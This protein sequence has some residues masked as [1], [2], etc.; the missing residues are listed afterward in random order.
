MSNKIGRFEIISRLAQSSFSTV[1]KALDPENG[2]TLALK[3]VPLSSV[4]D[5]QSLVKNVFEEADRSKPLNSHNIAALFGVGDED[6]KLIAGS[7]YVQGNSIATNLSRKEGFS[8]WDMQ[9][10][11]RQVCQALDH[12]QVHKV[13]H[14]SLEPAKIMVQWDGTVK[15]LGFGISSMN[16]MAAAPTGIPEVLYYLSPE[17]LRGEVC[18]HRSAL[19]SL[20]AILYEMATEQKAFSGQ[21]PERVRAAILEGVPAY[22]HRVKPNVSQGLSALIM[23][24]ISKSPKDRYQSGQE[25]MRDLEQ[26]NASPA[27]TTVVPPAPRKPQAAAAAA[28]FAGKPPAAAA[29]RGLAGKPQAAAAAPRVTGKPLPAAA[30]GITG[31]ASIPRPPVPP[32]PAPKVSASTAPARPSVPPAPKIAVDPLMAE[33][34]G[35]KASAPARRSFSE[36]EELPP[37]KD[38]FVSPSPAEKP[39][40]EQAESA[41]VLPP[42]AF[43][44]SAPEKPALQVREAAQ[45]AVAEIRKTPPKLFMYAVSVAGLVIAVIVAAMIIHN[46]MADH[47]NGSAPAAQAQPAQA[48]PAPAPSSTPPSTPAPPAAPPAAAQAQPAPAQPAPAPVAQQPEATAQAEPAV[49]VTEPRSSRKHRTRTPAAPKL[50]Q[51]AVASTPSGAQITF[52]GHPLCQSPCTLTDIAAGPHSVAASKSGYMPVTRTIHITRGARTTVSLQLSPLAATLLVSST[53]AGAAIIIDGRDTG[54]LTPTQFTVNKPGIHTV[55]VRRSGYLD[56][57]SSVNTQI[58]QSTIV[59]ATLTRLGNTD[60]I[61]GAGGKFKKV[62]GH[63]GGSDMGIVSIK[64]QPKGAQIMVNNRVLEKTAPYDFYLNPGTYVIDI[65]LSGYRSLHRVVNV[66]EGEKV[67]IQESLSRQ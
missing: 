15:V 44:K 42:S 40:S 38:I 46:Y 45:R 11:T 50:G 25:L 34:D 39:A 16:S 47:E 12:A 65:T 56:S 32:K 51:L 2:Q 41:S 35:S 27:K 31:K 63:G 9:D 3:I 57:A 10:I 7:E 4:A 58:G 55:L 14:H 6:G 48:K 28:G 30:P 54:R 62:F 64:T 13:L 20:G 1:C 67:T 18:D 26:C 49:V 53:P 37:L 60:D 52:D 61:R 59:N 33:D 43:K 19:F 36:M 21:T 66:Q 24:A 5:R 23:K 29:A 17:Q 22:P 8:I